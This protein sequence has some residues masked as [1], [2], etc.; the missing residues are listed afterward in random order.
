M[1]S[2]YSELGRLQSLAFHVTSEL[3]R[4]SDDDDDDDNRS[5]DISWETIVRNARKKFQYKYK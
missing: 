5:L 2:M 3:W 1:F 4:N